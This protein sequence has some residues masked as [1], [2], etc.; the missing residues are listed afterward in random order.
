M[1]TDV[2]THTHACG[3]CARSHHTW[4]ILW[5]SC[6]VLLSL[7]NSILNLPISS[8]SFVLAS[9]AAWCWATIHPAVLH[10]GTSRLAPALH[11]DKHTDLFL[12]TSAGTLIGD[13]FRSTIAMSK[14]MRTKTNIYH[15]HVD[16]KK[17]W[18]KWTYTQNRATGIEN[19]LMA[20]K[21]KWGEKNKLGVWD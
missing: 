2:G 14:G 3:V 4:L 18:Y 20:V 12:C 1:H 9:S 8:L 5:L 10:W 6:D 21:G 7:S 19:K 15:L 16:S 13:I 17:K 11:D